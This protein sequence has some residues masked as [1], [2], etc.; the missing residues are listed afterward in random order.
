[1]SFLIDSSSIEETQIEQT[2]GTSRPRN[3]PI[4]SYE[5]IYVHHPQRLKEYG[6]LYDEKILQTYYGDE[7]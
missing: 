7:Y 2:I 3:A 5:Y 4:P 6:K 1:L